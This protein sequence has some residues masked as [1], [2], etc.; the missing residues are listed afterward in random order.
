MTE[1][2]KPN[3][4]TETVSNVSEISVKQNEKNGS[5]VPEE[6]KRLRG[7]GMSY[8]EVGKELGMSKSK[9]FRL[10]KNQ[11]STKQ[12]NTVPEP[13]ESEENTGTLPMEP[14]EL[15][16]DVELKEE[17]KRLKD[18]ISLKRLRAKL[19]W[20]DY[21]AQNP[22]AYLT[23]NQNWDG[24]GNPRQDSEITRLREEIRDL[25]T[26][27]QNNPYGMA[28]LT[29]DAIATG[30][31]LAPKGSAE[32]PVELVLKGSQMRGD[33]EKNVQS[34]YQYGVQKGVIDVKLKEME[35]I[36]A[37]EDKKLDFE[38][39]KWKVAKDNEGRTIEQVKD[40]IKTVSEGPIGKAIENLGSG[41]A[42]KIR[43][44][45]KVAMVKIVC[46]NCNMGFP[47]NPKLETVQ[48]PGCGSML[49]KPSEPQ[50]QPQTQ[51]PQPQVPSAETPQTETPQAQPQ[52]TLSE[53]KKPDVL[54]DF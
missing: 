33:I 42:D 47:V 15:M 32:N 53:P 11:P 7:M 12:A 27:I 44:G 52:E 8:E 39:L 3:N 16:S 49:Q 19:R 5:N 48:C 23:M 29:L 43:G 24:H 6:A 51:E 41:A 38:V 20:L 26:S 46:P 50:P 36:G 10:L 21:I 35:Q 4:E 13:S 31:N 2:P 54:T 34:Q 14:P 18:E 17:S 45:P 37:I 30:Y 25:K 1:K 40:L 28:K 22:S 9:V